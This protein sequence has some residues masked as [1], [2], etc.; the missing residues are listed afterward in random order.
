PSTVPV[1]AP[2]IVAPAVPGPVVVV[3]PKREEWVTVGARKTKT[4]AVSAFG[5]TL[6]GDAK[7]TGR[8]SAVKETVAHDAGIRVSLGDFIKTAAVEEDEDES[9][10]ICDFKRGCGIKGCKK[11]HPEKF[12]PPMPIK[13]AT[14]VRE[15][16]SSSAAGANGANA[17]AQPAPRIQRVLNVLV[18]PSAP[19]K[20]A[21]V[22]TGI[23]LQKE[24]G[25]M[26]GL[27]ASKGGAIASSKGMKKVVRKLG[28]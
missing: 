3:P 11:I 23:K 15:E 14:S 2:I 24:V 21:N 7:H 13:S 16:A 5:A 18:I 25:K 6:R 4:S 20:D 28:K 12:C 17:A 9:H 1:P 22:K 26:G 8:G 27:P 10:F 19:A